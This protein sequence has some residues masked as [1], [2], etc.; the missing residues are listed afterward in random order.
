MRIALGIE[1]DG[2]VFT[3]WQTQ[4]GGRGVQDALEN[5]LAQVAEHPAHG[6]GLLGLLDRLEHLVLCV[7][8]TPPPSAAIGAAVTVACY[9]GRPSPEITHPG[10]AGP[11]P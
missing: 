2:A 11:T 8:E 1:Y 5:A 10:P 9:H 3:G 4:T 7:H 6:H